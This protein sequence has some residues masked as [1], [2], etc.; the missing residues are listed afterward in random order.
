MIPL[1]IMQKLTLK[2]IKKIIMA[3]IMKDWIIFA[4]ILQESI[5]IIAL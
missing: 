5:Q 1:K 2:I 4:I 3:K